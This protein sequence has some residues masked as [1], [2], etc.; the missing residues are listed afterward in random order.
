MDWFALTLLCAFAVATSDTLVKK[1]FSDGSVWDLLL[2]RFGIPSLLLFPVFFVFPFARMPAEFYSLMAVLIVLE[3]S[4]MLCYM[5]AISTT[6]LYL[7]LPY[8]AFTPVFNIITGYLF[9]G[10]TVTP[11][12]SLGI[13]LIFAGAYGLNI[14]K[15]GRPNA[16]SFLKPLRAIANNSGSRLMLLTAFI[17]SFTSVLSKRVMGHTEPMMF[18]AFYYAVI[19]LSAFLLYALAGQRPGRLLFHRAGAGFLVGFFMVVM[20]ISHFLAISKI[21]VAYM[22]SVKRTSLLFGI[23]Y[24]AWLFKEH[25]L[26][27]NLIAGS[28]M[29]IGVALILT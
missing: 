15:I 1:Y 19:G 26:G 13:L 28:L 21:E 24:G 29:V 7:T 11:E 8:L 16:R 6:P 4:A 14:E 17:Y 3:L 27:R 10:E 2:I 9:L 20:V 5:R 25:G 22:V 18:G 12:G 23:L